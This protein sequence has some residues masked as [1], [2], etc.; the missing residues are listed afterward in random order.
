LAG[1]FSYVVG[2][3]FYARKSMPLRYA[4]WHIFVNIGGILMFIG[5]WFAYFIPA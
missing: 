5:I 1:A 2:T 3:A 4:I